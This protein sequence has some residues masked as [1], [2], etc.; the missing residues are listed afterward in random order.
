MRSLWDLYF[1]KKYF[2][3]G[4]ELHYILRVIKSIY[5]LIV[6]Q[7]IIDMLLLTKERGK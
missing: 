6:I 1:A 2:G 5:F 3:M 4:R 7:N